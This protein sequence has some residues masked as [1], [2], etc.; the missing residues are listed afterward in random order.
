MFRNRIV[1]ALLA[2]IVLGLAAVA[3]GCAA[4]ASK[5]EFFGKIE[6]PPGQT[7]RYISGSE[8]E[9][10]D[11]HRSSGQPETRIFMALYDGLVEYHPKTMQPIPAIAER[12]TLD[13]D[14]TEIVFHLRRDAK[15]SNGDPI[16]ARDFVYSFRR[17]LQPELAARSA[18]LAYEIKYAQGVNEGGSFVRDPATGRFV[19]AAEAAPPAEKAPAAA[20][21]AAGAAVKP[22]DGTSAAPTKEPGDQAAA[23]KKEEEPAA[24]PPATTDPEAL[25]RAELSKK[26]EDAA[27]DTEFHKYMHQPT[28]LVVP[29]EAKERE[30]LFKENPKL[31]GLL[32]GKEFVP[33]KPEDLGVEAVDD[34]TLRLTLMQPAPY[35]IGLLPHQFFRVIH[36]G[37]VE[38]HGV[39]WTRPE[40]IVVSGAFTLKSHRPYNEVHVV[41]NQQY[42]DA[43]TV[44][45]DEIRFYPLEEQTTM[46]NLYKA[47]D[48]D[49]TYNHT[50]PAAWLKS[51]VRE[52]KDYMDA[53]E[54]AIEYYQINTTKA[55]MN[56]RRVRKAFAM[57]V[58]RKALADYRVVVKPLTAFSPEGIYPGYPQPKGDD[59]NPERA[60]QLLAEAGYKD[61]S[62]KFDPSK[63]PVSEVEITYNTSESNRA[64]AEFIQ[65]Q[66]KQ[67][68]GM[69]IPLKNVEWKS[70]LDMRSK[71]QYKGFARAGWVGDF[72]DPYTFLALFSTLGHDNGTGWI[73][74]K[75][76]AKLKAANSEPDQTKRYALLAEAEAYLLDVQ[77]VL[78]LV[79]PA[80][81]WMKKPYV[82]GLYPNPGTLHA[83][84]YVYI[85]HDRAKWDK[86]MPD[87][88]SES[89][90]D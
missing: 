73:D 7:L 65:A 19:T 76:V 30:K 89:L 6:P 70:F 66:W 34:H 64:V 72:M 20:A 43:A 22:A 86:Q 85:E 69:T 75:Y 31:Q 48:V 39:A 13:E 47:G 78:P 77:P 68:L 3:A 24:A 36:E 8:P 59:F 53:P 44:R 74:Q 2:S 38:R 84:K 23:Q 54:N 40:N 61:A 62:G 42:W 11:P 58:D 32:A 60:K 83:W 52:M 14:A 45:L 55:P 41:K 15:F 67:H 46:L 80:T 63:F 26:G 35:F 37:A 10:L 29:S 90:A 27:P 81:S 9:S 87:M 51:G 12:W 82:K 5:S 18:Y 16:T 88:K 4:Q 56:D 57:G 79:T 25:H 21:E 17:G 49:A 50:V 71:L 33:V 28:R 1:T